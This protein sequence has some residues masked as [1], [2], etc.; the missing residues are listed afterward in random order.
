MPTQELVK[1]TIMVIIFKCFLCQVCVNCLTRLFSLNSSTTS[2]SSDCYPIS[3]VGRDAHTTKWPQ[4]SILI[5]RLVSASNSIF[6][7][8]SPSTNDRS[9]LALRVKEVQ[10]WKRGDRCHTGGPRWG[11]DKAGKSILK[12]YYQIKLQY[13]PGMWATYVILSFMV[14]TS[15]ETVKRNRRYKF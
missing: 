9:L 1:I 4:L 11:R 7:E 15:R 3:Q 13:K 2:L 12:Q 14:V 10:N 8:A 6:Q 5:P